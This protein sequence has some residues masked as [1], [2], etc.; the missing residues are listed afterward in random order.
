[1][2]SPKLTLSEKRRLVLSYY[3]GFS[4]DFVSHCLRTLVPTARSVVD[5]WNG[6]GTTTFVCAK[7]GI[8]AYGNVVFA[9][10]H[11]VTAQGV[12]AYPAEVTVQMVANFSAGGAAIN[13]L[14][15]AAGAVAPRRSRLA[16]EPTSR[17][18]SP[19]A[20]RARR[21]PTSSPPSPPATTPSRPTAICLCLWPTGHR[22]HH[23][24]PRRSRPPCSAAAVS[25]GP[26]AAPASTI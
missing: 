24:R 20:R 4:E 14:A 6:S 26:A 1:M 10:N 17:P 12:S 19:P 7:N 8:E 22:Q 5:P 13:Q 16:L 3:A 11:G 2:A 15:R 18:T 25:A 21:R 9:G 23:R